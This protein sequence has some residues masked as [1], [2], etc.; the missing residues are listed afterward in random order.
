MSRWQH[1]RALADVCCG[2]PELL[3]AI[4]CDDDVWW[5]LSVVYCL[6]VYVGCLG[7][8]VWLVVFRFFAYFPLLNCD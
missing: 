6:C 1:V 4:T 8:V 2:K 5:A 3:I 7:L